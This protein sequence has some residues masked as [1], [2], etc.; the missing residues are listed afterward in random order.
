MSN[1]ILKH[2]VVIL[3][4]VIL[5]ILAV[6]LFF[7][8]KKTPTTEQPKNPAQTEE[9]RL[10]KTNPDP[11][12]NTTILPTQNL[13][14]TFNMPIYRSEFKHNF[15]P[16]IPHDIEMVDGIDS[17]HGTTIRIKF[18]EPLKLGSGYTLFVEAGTKVND[19]L[20]LNRD[21]IYH[22]TTIHYRGV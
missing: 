16:E 15:D 22:F 4:L 11:L 6:F 14:F 10:L 19:K 12:D 9:L 21:Y 5:I 17:E 2:K 3:I 20:K 13:E 18:R 7:Y 8:V 1:G